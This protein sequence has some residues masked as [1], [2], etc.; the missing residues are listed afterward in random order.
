L[1]SYHWEKVTS[2]SK[3]SAITDPWVLYLHWATHSIQIQIL[4]HQHSLAGISSWF[5]Q[6]LIIWKPLPYPSK[7]HP[8]SYSQTKSIHEYWLPL[9]VVVVCYIWI[10]TAN[11]S[12]RCLLYIWIST[13]NSSNFVC[14]IWILTVIKSSCYLLFTSVQLVFKQDIHI[15]HPLLTYICIIVGF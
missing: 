10:P 3:T 7:I 13:S 1:S 4:D 5:R 12:S 8:Y 2:Q 15:R 14:Y 9:T 6:S 11:S